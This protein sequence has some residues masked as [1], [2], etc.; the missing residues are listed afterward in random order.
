METSSR[1]VESQ[2]DFWN[3]RWGFEGEFGG[4]LV[5]GVWRKR[6]MRMRMRVAM[7]IEANESLLRKRRMWR[8]IVDLSM[9]EFSFLK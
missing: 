2:E 8:S 6:K 4:M 9:E 3:L 7:V 5:C 1:G